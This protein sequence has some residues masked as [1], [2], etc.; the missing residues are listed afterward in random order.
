MREEMVF[1]SLEPDWIPVSIGE[2]KFIL[3][4]PSEAASVAWHNSNIRGARY[5]DGKLVSVGNVAEGQPL[6]VSLCLFYVDN[7]ADDTSKWRVRRDK[8]GAEETV[9]LATV[10]SWRSSVVSR[11][12]E[13]A[14]EMGRIGVKEDN[15]YRELLAAAIETEDP[16][17]DLTYYLFREWVQALG[18][19]NSKY[20]P[21]LELVDDP[22]EQAA[23]N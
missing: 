5:Q 13:K 22:E 12:F 7:P 23:K 1:D 6:L 11:M 10:K 16:P 21:L 3:R 15:P 20:A 17:A 8:S 2:G 4:E 14:K 19:S 18:K 9:P